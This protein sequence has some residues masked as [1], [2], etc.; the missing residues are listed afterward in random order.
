MKM[1]KKVQQ[2]FTL[3]EL[4][5]VVAIIG[6]LAS[7]ALPAYQD[8]ITRSKISEGL[9]LATAYKTGITE[10]FQANAT[11]FRNNTTGCTSI[12]TDCQLWGITYIGSAGNSQTAIVNEISA[13]KTGQ[14]SIVYQP[15]ILVS[16]SNLM[17]LTPASAYNPSTG[18]STQVDLNSTSTSAAQMFQWVCSNNTIEEKY[19]PANCRNP[20]P[21]AP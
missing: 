16:G 14:V 4:M 20:E 5:I 19:V 15:A 7:I 13:D 10:T 11:R 8:Y 18:A 9:A 6:I 3:I 21:T 17:H 2:G 1:M 12:T